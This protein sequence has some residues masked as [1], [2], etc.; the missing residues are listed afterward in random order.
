MNRAKHNIGHHVDEPRI[1]I[2]RFGPDHRQPQHLAHSRCLVIEVVQHLDVIAHEPN[3]ADNCC[4]ESARVLRAQ[5][6]AHI[7][8]EPR[9]LGTSA[10]T[11]IHERPVGDAGRAATSRD[12]SCS[13]SW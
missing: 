8:F 3:R 10:A 7:R 12:D 2:D 1:V 4:P 11:L 9:I 13:S 5:V 6:V